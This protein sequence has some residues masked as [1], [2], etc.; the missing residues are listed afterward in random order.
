M[1]TEAKSG[2]IGI[3]VCTHELGDRLNQL[4]NLSTRLEKAQSRSL[5]SDIEQGLGH[6]YVKVTNGK[7]NTVPFGSE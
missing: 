3:G 6:Y 1:N 2:K 7:E 5:N 4:Q